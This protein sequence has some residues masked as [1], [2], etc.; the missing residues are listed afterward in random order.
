VSAAP[1]RQSARN[2]SKLPSAQAK[3]TATTAKSVKSKGDRNSRLHKLASW[4][5]RYNELLEFKRE[6]GDCRVPKEYKANL[7]LGTWVYHQRRYFKCKSLSKDRIALLNQIGFTWEMNREDNWMKRYGEL[8]E[9]KRE[10]GHCNVLT[11]YKA[12]PSLAYWV[13]AQRR[14]FKSKSL[15]K[16]RIA[17]LNQ[18]G[19][20]WEINR[21]VDWIEQYNELV[22]Y[23]FKVGDCN[24]PGKYKANPSLAYWVHMQRKLFKSKSLSRDQIAKLNQIGFTW[25]F[26]DDNWMKQYNELVEYKFKVGDCNVPSTYKANPSLA[27]WV[28]SQRKLFKSKSLPEKRVA[29]LNQIGFDWECIRKIK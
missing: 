7:Q 5:T 10:L 12:N 23:K 11:S 9:H 22:E 1:Y 28:H 8:V 20:T 26:R 18:I 19:F 4:K 24:V 16:D 25:E 14:L 15:S 2:L 6:F 3:S 27:Y 29:K 21:K 13:F 17:R